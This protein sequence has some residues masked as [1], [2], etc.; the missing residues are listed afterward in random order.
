[1]RLNLLPIALLAC[2]TAAHAQHKHVHGEGRLDVTI[3]KDTI[4]LNLELPLDAA[5]GFERAPK[6]DKDKAALANAQKLIHE[7][8]AL[9]RPTPAAQ[10]TVQSVSVVMPT[11]SGGEHADVDARYVFHCANP[12][13]LK[14]IETTLFTQFKRLY[15]LQTQRIGPAGQGAQRLSPKQPVLLW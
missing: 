12:A 3:E 2:L 14:G 8:A 4:T 13:A 10:C 15:R 6:N 11:F 7:A 9:W 5:V 1:M